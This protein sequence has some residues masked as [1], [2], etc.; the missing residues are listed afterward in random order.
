MLANETTGRATVAA[1]FVGTFLMRQH[2]GVLDCGDALIV[3][4]ND[5]YRNDRRSQEEVALL[6]NRLPALDLREAGFGVD[7]GDGY[8]WA[9]VLDNYQRLDA[10]NE[11]EDAVRAAW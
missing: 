7:D 4:G 10:I 5:G 9:L 6:R 11:L 8:A 1:N 3:F 2:R